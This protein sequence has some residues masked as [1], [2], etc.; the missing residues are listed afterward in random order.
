MGSLRDKTTKAKSKRSNKELPYEKV[1]ELYNQGKSASTIAAEL[2]LI[3]KN[4]ASPAWRVA[5]IITKLQKGHEIN[6]K[7]LKV[8]MRR[9]SAAA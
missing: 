4:S 1:M 9:A 8:K 2:G 7:K 3:D 5:N 6:G